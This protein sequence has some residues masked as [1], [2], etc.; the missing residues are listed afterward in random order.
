MNKQLTTQ[1]QAPH[2]SLVSVRNC[3]EACLNLSRV[4]AAGIV[5]NLS[6]KQCDLVITAD[7]DPVKV[8]AAIKEEAG[9]VEVKVEPKATPTRKTTKAKK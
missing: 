6:H 8:K 4:E 7:G 2:E 9:P 3:V 1:E 5:N